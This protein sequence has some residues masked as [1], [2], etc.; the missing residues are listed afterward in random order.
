MAAELPQE[1]LSIIA[2]YSAADNQ[3][4]A[5][6]ALVNRAWQAAF[7]G[8]IYSTLSVLS[9]SQNT[10]IVVRDDLR[11]GKRGLTLEQLACATGGSQSRCIARK[12]AIRR[13]IYKVAVPHWLNNERLKED[14]FSYD[15][16]MRRE[17]DEAFCKG[18]PP[19]F[20]VLSSWG[21]KDCPISLSIVLQA[22]HV[23]TSGQGGEPLTK[24]YSGFG[25]MITSYRADLLSDCH[26]ATASCVASLDFPEAWAPAAMGSENGV[27]PSAALKIS[28]ACGGDKLLYTR[29]PGDYSI[30]PHDA[31][32]EAQKRSGT[33]NRVCLLPTSVR[34]LDIDWTYLT[35]HESSVRT[36]PPTFAFQPDALSAALHTVSLQLRELHTENLHLLPDFF[37]CSSSCSHHWP[38]LE[39]LELL[40]IPYE[41]FGIDLRYDDED[42][43]E[44]GLARNYFDSLYESVGHAARQMPKLEHLILSFGEEKDVLEVMI[45]RGRWR[46]AIESHNCYSPSLRVLQAWKADEKNQDTNAAGLFIAEYGSWPP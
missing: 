41:V 36:S 6:F 38:N 37:R 17:N 35:A 5:Q 31:V 46:L 24:S 11:F 44:P 43:S 7:E 14:G 32:C 1:I 19:L 13:I 25:Q 8:K 42:T 21:D 23:Y 22:E 15:N 40:L 20:E 26:I 27:S 10:E 29:I 9:P 12:K 39:I 28:A 18:V 34:R 2:A 30:R 4:L 3:K 33:A 16:F 45:R